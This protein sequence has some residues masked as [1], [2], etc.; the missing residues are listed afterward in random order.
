MAAKLEQLA[1]LAQDEFD[2]EFKAFAILGPA[3]AHHI[4]S[5]LSAMFPI[6]LI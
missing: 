1:L 3:S 4:L 5:K 6:F 2:I